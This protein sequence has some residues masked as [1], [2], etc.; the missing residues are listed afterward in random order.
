MRSVVLGVL[1][2]GLL[3]GTTA[4]AAEY[5][6]DLGAAATT[7]LVEAKDYW[8]S[9]RGTS[10][11]AEQFVRKMVKRGVEE[12]LVEKNTESGQTTFNNAITTIRGEVDSAFATTT[13]TVP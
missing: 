10:V 9:T 8:N 2:V 4:C 12:V 5:C 3:F 7:K 1:V 11:T 13:T 6:T